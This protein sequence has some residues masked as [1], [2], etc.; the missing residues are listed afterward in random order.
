[1]KCLRYWTDDRETGIDIG[2]YHIQLDTIDEYDHYT[3][4]YLIVSK[5]VRLLKLK[6]KIEIS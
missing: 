3:I 4:R 1:M 2:P 5:E 6:K